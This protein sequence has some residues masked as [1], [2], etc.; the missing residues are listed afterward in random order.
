MGLKQP[1][2]L[3]HLLQNP[4][5]ARNMV[6]SLVSIG[7]WCRGDTLCCSVHVCIADEG[8]ADANVSSSTGANA[9][10]EPRLS[11]VEGRLEQEAPV[12]AFEE[13][14]EGSDDAI[15][16]DGMRESASIPDTTTAARD[17]DVAHASVEHG[18]DLNTN[19]DEP[20]NDET[21]HSAP[22]SNSFDSSNHQADKLH[23]GAEADQAD[24]VEELLPNGSEHA[25]LTSLD[26]DD[27]INTADEVDVAMD[28]EAGGVAGSAEISANA[29]AGD[30]DASMDDSMDEIS[31]PSVP[32]GDKPDET[33]LGSTV[34]GVDGP[35]DGKPTQASDGA[36]EKSDGVML[37]VL[38]AEAESPL[39]QR[40]APSAGSTGTPS[41]RSRGKARRA[42]PVEVETSDRTAQSPTTSAAH[43]ADD[44]PTKRRKGASGGVEPTGARAEN[45]VPSSIDAEVRYTPPCAF[46]LPSV[47]IYLSRPSV[48]I[49]ASRPHHQKEM[50]SAWF[51]VDWSKARQAAEGRR[52]SRRALLDKAIQLRFR[53][54]Q[55]LV[56]GLCRAGVTRSPLAPACDRA[57]P[58]SS[59]IPPTPKLETPNSGSAQKR[60][61]SRL[62][63]PTY[64]HIDPKLRRQSAS[65]LVAA[66][67][68]V[69][70]RFS[71]W[72]G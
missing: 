27:D 17:A 42:D 16:H 37:P 36:M 39:S 22:Q 12:S 68:I 60:S 19:D 67:P 71:F 48:K 65:C 29:A 50:W 23:V 24:E 34:S 63:P 51:T 55:S 62:P 32:A 7:D 6:R 58:P 46:T 66:R 38:E 61:R 25:E 31:V 33:E 9:D 57:P 41:K 3:A 2:I 52:R 20:S 30:G 49:H 59:P 43:A 21:T 14:A 70:T 8:F 11:E 53:L 69:R 4:K 15:E 56:V 40:T 64:E 28:V 26:A 18:I 1:I 54:C 5:M 35:V 47:K 13:A 10:V 44:P 72:V 45:P